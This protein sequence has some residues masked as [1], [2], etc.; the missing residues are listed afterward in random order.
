MYKKCDLIV[1]IKNQLINHLKNNNLISQCTKQ[2]ELVIKW[3]REHDDSE[4]S[5]IF[6]IDQLT[7]PMCQ[8]CF[9]LIINTALGYYLTKLPNVSNVNQFK[10]LY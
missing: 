1:S 6:N 7:R 2:K 10:E 3:Y 9:Q 8:K 4:W 5:M